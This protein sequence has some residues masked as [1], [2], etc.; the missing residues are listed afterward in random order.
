MSTKSN[1]FL[2]SDQSEPHSNRTK[3]I[4]AQHPEIRALIGRNPYSF[5]FILGLTLLQVSIAFGLRH[6][7]WWVIVIVA[8]LIG[9]FVNHAL[10]MLIHECSHNLIFKKQ[11]P[12]FLAGIIANLTTVVPTSIPFKLYHMK[13]H[14]FQGVY[15]LDADL[16]SRWE[17]TVF[18]GT[19][20]GRIIW[21]ALF[22]LLQ[23]IRPAR[24]RDIHLLNRWTIINMIAVFAFD[25]LV[26]VAFGWGAVGYLALSMYLSYSLHPVMGRLIQEHFVFSFPQETYSYYGPLNKLSFNVG[27]HNEHHDFPSIPWNRLPQVRQ[28]ASPWY[29]TLTYHTS[30]TQL[31]FM[32]IFNTPPDIYGRIERTNRGGLRT[33][34]GLE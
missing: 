8:Y 27:Y 26:L 13:H 29:D 30:W 22:P 17:V 33:T 4:L 20:I 7:P 10:L 12:N 19:A 14:S 2:Q 1:V 9:A 23:A 32:F 3:A 5:G 28:I 24:L 11:T 34:G 6:Q 21:L 18:G 15:D 31:L 25:Y 16:P